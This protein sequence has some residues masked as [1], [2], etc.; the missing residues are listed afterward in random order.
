MFDSV[1]VVLGLVLNG[2]PLLSLPECDPRR[3]LVHHHP[4]EFPRRMLVSRDVEGYVELIATLGVDGK[5]LEVSI[6]ESEPTGFFDRAASKAVLK[7]QYE[8]GLH[9]CRQ[10]QKLSF[11]L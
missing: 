8:P 7:W 6:I 5:V 11:E 9:Q 4:P 2:D 3:E 10:T 1:L